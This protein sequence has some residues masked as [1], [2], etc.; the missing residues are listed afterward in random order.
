MKT[1]KGR[2]L[3]R[4]VEGVDEEIAKNKRN[5]SFTLLHRSSASLLKSMRELSTDNKLN[6]NRI[7][8]SSSTACFHCSTSGDGGAGQGEGYEEG[9]RKFG[10][11]STFTLISS[12]IQSHHYSYTRRLGI[13]QLLILSLLTLIGL[14]NTNHLCSAQKLIFGNS[15]NPL[16]TQNVVIPH[17]K[18]GQGLNRWSFLSVDRDNRKLNCFSRIN[19]FTFLNLNSM[20][21]YF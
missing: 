9:S 12:K 19:S 18:Y 15:H 11:S 1:Q 14:L 13:R 2:R 17:I 10:A 16:Q 7:I 8:C 5:K 6:N 21:I 20:A 3:L 4:R